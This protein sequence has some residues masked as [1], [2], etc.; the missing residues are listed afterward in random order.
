LVVIIT[1]NKIISGIIII[2]KP[3]ALPPPSPAADAEADEDKAVPAAEA[4]VGAAMAGFDAAVI[5]SI[6]WVRGGNQGRSTWGGWG[7]GRRKWGGELGGGEVEG[8]EGEIVER[9]EGGPDEALHF[10]A[11]VL[12]EV[13]AMLSHDRIETTRESQTRMGYVTYLHIIV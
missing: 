8:G 10:L 1:T 3:P 5:A 6:L 13:L 12:R 7:L 2:Y 9:N 4:A 11:L